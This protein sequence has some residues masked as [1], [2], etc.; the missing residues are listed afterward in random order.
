M[1]NQDKSYI[2][3]PTLFTLL[4]YANILQVYHLYVFVAI[5]VYISLSKLLQWGV[6][7][8]VKVL[9]Y[10]YKDENINSIP[11]KRIFWEGSHEPQTELVSPFKRVWGYPDKKKKKKSSC[12]HPFRLR[13]RLG[14]R[15]KPRSQKIQIFFLLKF[16]M[17]CIF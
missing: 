3:I 13:I 11:R 6:G 15:C 2:S 10:L 14:T 16:N 8:T 12:T 4:C 17:F 9:L 1:T 5:T 7:L